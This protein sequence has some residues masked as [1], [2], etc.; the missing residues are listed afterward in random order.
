MTGRCDDEAMEADEG[1]AR[2]IHEAL[3]AGD[4]TAFIGSFCLDSTVTI[5][6]KFDLSAVAKSL[7]AYLR[8]ARSISR[9]E[10]CNYPK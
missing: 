2:A 5:D 10:S 3:W 8:G 4:S 6:G 9:Q 7:Q 1:L